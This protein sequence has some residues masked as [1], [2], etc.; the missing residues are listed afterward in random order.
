MLDW[1]M[2]PD[3]KKECEIQFKKYSDGSFGFGEHINNELEGRG[4]YLRDDFFAFIGNFFFFKQ[5]D[6][7]R[8][9]APG[10]YVVFSCFGWLQVGKIKK[11]ENG[12]LNDEFNQYWKYS[13][14]I[15]SE[16]YSSSM[17]SYFNDNTDID[18]FKEIDFQL[19]DKES[20]FQ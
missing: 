5:L 18:D 2:A 16:G 1:I 19:E 8:Y 12:E 9:I 6:R 3:L 4:F 17:G 7:H 11:L 14:T 10:E 15:L 20:T 13:G